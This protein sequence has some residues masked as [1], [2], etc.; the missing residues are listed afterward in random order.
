MKRNLLI[1]VT[2]A[3]LLMLGVGASGSKRKTINITGWVSDEA[4]G[5]EHAKPGGEDCVKKCLMGGAHVGHPEW[6]AQ[7]MVF[8]T[9][10]GKKIWIVANP[11]SLKGFEGQHVQITGQLDVVRKTLRVTTAK[12]VEEV[13]AVTTL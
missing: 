6:K 2:I 5:A 10:A 11:E 13:S 3:T 4:C 7:R 12:S 1:A 8:V 9:D